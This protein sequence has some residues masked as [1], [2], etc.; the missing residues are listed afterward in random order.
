GLEEREE[1]AGELRAA[2]R[3]QLDEHDRGADVAQRGLDAL[4]AD[5][6][7]PLGA[8]AAVV[9]AEAP[10]LDAQRPQ[11]DELDAGWRRD[12]RGQLAA[13]QQHDAEALGQAAAERVGANQVAEP[14]RVLAVE[15]QRR[16]HRAT[17]ASVTRSVAASS[18]ARRCASVSGRTRLTAGSATRT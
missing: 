14:D 2:E 3:E 10:A 18:S 5:G 1:L 8:E 9:A 17:P 11:R 13:H 4:G 7:G 16:P 15:E 12:P 6:P